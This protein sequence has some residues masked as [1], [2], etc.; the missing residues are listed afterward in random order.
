ME[1]IKIKR[2]L[3]SVSDKTGLKPLALALKNYG[4]EIISS[5]GTGLVLKEWGIDFTPIEQ[6]TGNPEAF[7]GRMK[8]LS[9]PIA[10]ALL[11]RRENSA[12]QKQAAELGIE[13]I[14]LVICNLYPFAEVAKKHQRKKDQSMVE[15]IE[16]IDIGGP[17]MIRAAAKNYRAVAVCIHPDQYPQLLESLDASTGS[18]DL[19]TRRNL[20]LCA[21]RETAQY[22]AIIAD[23]LE[24]QWSADS[25]TFALAAKN[26]K[27]LRYGENPHQK[28][29]VYTD[30]LQPGLAG[31]TPLQGRPLSYNN[32][33]DADAAFKCTNDL[34]DTFKR[35]TDFAVTIVKHLNPCGA[36]VSQNAFAALKL[37]WAGDPISS[38]GSII[39]FSGIVTEECAAWLADK[40]V[41]VLIAPAFS[42]EALLL[43]EK[44]KNLRL[45][46]CD[47]ATVAGNYN[48]RSISGG[49]LV[50]TEDQGLDETTSAVTETPFSNAKMPL[51]EFGTMVNKHLK[52]NAIALVK[53]T[54]VGHAL[55]GAG[56]GN[57]NR[58]ISTQQ[59]LEKAKENGEEDFSELILISDAFFPFADNIELAHRAGITHI[60]QPGGSIKDR[61][62][63]KKCNELGMSMIFTGRRHFRH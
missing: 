18:T 23:V 52:S 38:F 8:T 57:P 51:V 41:E 16:N 30:P 17:T 39:C 7:A 9:F 29:W 24:Q 50:Q 10:S 37:A 5:G 35:D 62:V 59:A 58:L 49:W 44:K 21:F 12:D 11:F 48:L 43:C 14:D 32:L 6:V 3:I 28:A 33:L 54:R 26:A 45:I 2:A 61:D 19:A 4:V 42:A 27:E 13:A 53:E 36:A 34:I 46:E 22:D 20:A 31:M 1:N 55:V 63:I 47:F 25:K 60:V 56:M 15:L 40:F